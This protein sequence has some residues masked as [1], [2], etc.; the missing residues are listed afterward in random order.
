[1]AVLSPLLPSLTLRIFSL[2]RN[3]KAKFTI[4]LLLW[5]FPPTTISQNLYH[6]KVEWDYYTN[7]LFQLDW[8][9]GN[10]LTTNLQASVSVPAGSNFIHAVSIRG[11]VVSEQTTLPFRVIGITLEASTDLIT[12]QPIATN[13]F[14]LTNNLTEFYRAKMMQ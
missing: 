3:G 8:S 2:L 5:L 6:V 14:L 1:M 13:R 12:W 4:I 10:Y 11:F 7:G 9:G